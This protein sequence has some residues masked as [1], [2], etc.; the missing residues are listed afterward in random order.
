MASHH[1][2]Q[3]RL[4]NQRGRQNQHQR[5]ESFRQNCKA[6][7]NSAQDETQTRWSSIRPK[8]GK[9]QQDGKHEKT[10]ERQIRQAKVAFHYPT[11]ASGKR[12]R[13]HYRWDSAEFSRQQ[14]V[15]DAKESHAEQRHRQARG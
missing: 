1:S 10:G 11:G 3:Y 2:R 4:K 15:K 7:A 14:Q 8:Q 9:Q 13:C 12:R 6:E 5:H